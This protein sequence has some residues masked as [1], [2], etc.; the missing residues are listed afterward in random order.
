MKP[1]IQNDKLYWHTS[2]YFEFR[3]PGEAITDICQSGANDEAVAYW[4]P[5]I[6]RYEFGEGHA[7]AP[8]P[9]KLRKD[10]H[11]YGAWDSEELADDDANW[12]R[13]VWLAAWN[14]YEGD[15]D[16]SEPVTT[17]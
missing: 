4:A 6:N 13:V 16:D 1:E 5:R 14:I 15:L 17:E 12:Q 8:T 3:L 10:L 2:N 11:E 9:E 7:W